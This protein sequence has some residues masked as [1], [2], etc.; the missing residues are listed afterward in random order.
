M[1][2]HGA[3]CDRLLRNFAN[4]PPL[5]PSSHAAMWQVVGRLSGFIAAIAHP[6][7]AF[8]A[9]GVLFADIK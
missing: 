7:C 4:G 9:V 6:V 5:H 2:G 8:G 1:Y 3:V